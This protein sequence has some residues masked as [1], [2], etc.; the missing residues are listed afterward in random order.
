MEFDDYKKVSLGRDSDIL[1]LKFK[2]N[3]LIVSNHTLKPLNETMLQ[4]SYQSFI[5]PLEPTDSPIQLKYQNFLKWLQLIV[6]ILQSMA[7]I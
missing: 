7:F 2:N 6:I 4:D 5:P 3:S 1:S